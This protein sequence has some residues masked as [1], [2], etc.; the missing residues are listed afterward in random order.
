M[1]FYLTAL[2]F[3]MFTV[4]FSQTK[5][6]VEK[7]I[8]MNEVPPHTLEILLKRIKNFNQVK[9][10]YQT[11]AEKK[12]YE[13]KFKQF[14]QNFSVE[15]DTS[16]KIINVE[17]IVKKR[18]ISSEILNN[19]LQNLNQEFDEFKIQKI[20]REYLGQAKDL[21]NLISENDI[22]PNLKIR[23]EILI[24]AKEEKTRRLYE[25]LYDSNGKAL[26]KREVILQ[27]TDI[28]DY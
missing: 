4:C 5:N 9:W 24:N 23:Y 14:S 3:L 6:E 11:D 7:R 10:Y 18:H 1:P 28:L 21:L 22:A 16:G 27:S 25:F 2:C 8:K 13:A 12:V 15:F 17:L 26:L 19:I 20:Q